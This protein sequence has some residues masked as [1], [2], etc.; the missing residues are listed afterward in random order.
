MRRRLR[1]WAVLTCAVA[2]ATILVVATLLH[3]RGQ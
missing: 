2:Y 1:D 3:Q